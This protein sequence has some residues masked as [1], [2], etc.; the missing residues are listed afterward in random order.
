MQ[1]ED[2]IEEPKPKAFT[3]TAG[4][5]DIRQAYNAHALIGGYNTKLYDTSKSDVGTAPAL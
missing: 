4:G 3:L 5:F 1:V 2:L